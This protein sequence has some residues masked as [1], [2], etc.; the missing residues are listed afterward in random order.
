[1]NQTFNGVVPEPLAQTSPLTILITGASRGIGFELV[2]QYSEAYSDNVVI[3]A[4]RDINKSEQLTTYSL[5]HPRVHIIP[6]DTSNPISIKESIKYLPSSVNHIDLLYN[7]A[8]IM[9][10]P[11]PLSDITSSQL[12]DTYNTNVV[13]P[14]LVVQTYTD[15]LLS[16]S[17]PSSSLS[18]SLS[19]SSSSSPAKVI[20]IS[21]ELG[22]SRLAGA[23]ASF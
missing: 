7:N 16:K 20:N 15:L 14:L 21:S 17:L 9:L 6:L 23:V 2:R 18:S 13:G 3:A 8:G 11:T 10:T 19:S 5:S 1:M 4:V 22:S 12:L